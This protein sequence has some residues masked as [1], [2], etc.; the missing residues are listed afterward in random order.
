[1]AVHFQSYYGEKA[2]YAG[3]YSGFGVS[4]SRFGAELGLAKL[5][6]ENRPELDMEFASTLP[7][8]I[9]PEPLRYLGA[10]V[11]MHALD[12]ADERGGWRNMWLLGVGKMGF[13]LSWTTENEESS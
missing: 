5:F 9:P 10:K 7:G 11:T 2:I 3:G 4:A 12:T 8:W 1:M 6:K 13:P